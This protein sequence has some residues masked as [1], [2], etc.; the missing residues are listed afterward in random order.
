MGIKVGGKALKSAVEKGIQS[1]IIYPALE[2]AEKGRLYYPSAFILSHIFFYR[3]TAYFVPP[4][5]RLPMALLDAR[6]LLRARRFP[7]Q[8]KPGT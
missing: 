4:E 5:D 1:M 7:D 2:D 6:A 3:V 8:L